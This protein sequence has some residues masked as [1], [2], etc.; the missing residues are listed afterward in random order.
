[1]VTHGEVCFIFSHNTEHE[2][3]R[4]ESDWG[5]LSHHSLMAQ[6]PRD[7]EH[8][9]GRGWLWVGT[10]LGHE[11]QTGSLIWQSTHL[12]DQSH[13]YEYKVALFFHLLQSVLPYST[14]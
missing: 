11:G 2:A 9:H 3:S 1:M 10:G 5:L 4:S 8:S 12:M 13:K 14:K 6:E 7:A